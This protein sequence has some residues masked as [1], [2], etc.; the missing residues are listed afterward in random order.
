MEAET[1]EQYKDETFRNLKKNES[2]HGDENGN[3]TLKDSRFNIMGADYFMSD[4][5]HML[6]QTYGSGAGGILRETGED[7]GQDLLD[8][9]NAGEN[10]NEAFGTLLG[11]LKFL[12]YSDPQIND[13]KIVFP[14]SPTAVEHLKKDYEQKRTCYFLTGVL[15]GAAKQLDEGIRFIEEECRANGDENCT[16]RVK[17]K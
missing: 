12:G 6:S 4:I 9:M 7:Y 11:L 2:M 13:D 8:I 14:S 17:E 5:L 3:V 16:F 10:F 1:I 15:S